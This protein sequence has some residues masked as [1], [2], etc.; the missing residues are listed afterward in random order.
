M[1][2]TTI[3]TPKLKGTEVAPGRIVFNMGQV[4]LGTVN[5][6]PTP[7]VKATDPIVPAYKKLSVKQKLIQWIEDEPVRRFDAEYH[8]ELY[9]ELKEK[10]RR[11]A[12]FAMSASI[13]LFDK[14]SDYYKSRLRKLAKQPKE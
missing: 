5:E 2:Q 4:A 8:T 12:I 6:A 10:R 13:G 9:N 11:D 3:T 14:E 7:P 1:K